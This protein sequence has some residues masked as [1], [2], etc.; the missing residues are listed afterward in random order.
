[1]IAGI[2]ID[3]VKI[4]RIQEAVQKWDKRF[5][6]RVFTPLEL[7]YCFAR[8]DPYLHLSG[9]FAVK[10]AAFKALGTGWRSG[11]RWIEIEILNNPQGKPMVTTTGRVKQLMADLGVANI[12]VSISHDT[13]YAIGQV[14]LSKFKTQRP[15]GKLTPKPTK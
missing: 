3:L 2:G 6:N 1:M 4:N 15:K 8:L 11:V 12:H 5:L 9:R 10:E 13:D 7:Q 14:I